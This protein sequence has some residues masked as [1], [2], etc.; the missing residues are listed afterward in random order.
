MLEYIR[1]AGTRRAEGGE[2]A[3]RSEK[4]ANGDIKST[5]LLEKSSSIPPHAGKMIAKGTSIVKGRLP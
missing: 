3:S 1:N 5:N 2:R 4:N